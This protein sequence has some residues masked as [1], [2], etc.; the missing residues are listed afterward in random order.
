VSQVAR[1]QKV[2]GYSI[3]TERYRYT[4]WND[5]KE[6]EELYD[7]QTDPKELK[8]IAKESKMKAELQTRLRA[9]TKTRGRA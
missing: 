3:R 2:M 4:E 9:I 6:G 7:Y 5:G 1:G 8:N